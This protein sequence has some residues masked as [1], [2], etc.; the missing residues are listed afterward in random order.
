VFPCVFLLTGNSACRG[1]G[2]AGWA[3]FL[4]RSDSGAR[5]SVWDDSACGTCDARP[6]V[7]GRVEAG[8]HGWKE[9]MCAKCGSEALAAARR[10]HD[11][12]SASPAGM[13]MEDVREEEEEAGAWGPGAAGGGGSSSEPDT[14]GAVQQSVDLDAVDVRAFAAAA[15]EAAAAAAKPL[16][17]VRTDED[18]HAAG[19]RDGAREAGGGGGEGGG[20]GLDARAAG[21]RDVVS[22]AE[23]GQREGGRERE[24]GMCG[25]LAGERERERERESVLLWATLPH[26]Q[27]V[28][29]E[30]NFDVDVAAAPGAA[31]APAASADPAAHTAWA[32]SV[33]PGMYPPPHMTPYYAAIKMH[34]AAAPAARRV[35]RGTTGGAGANIGR[36]RIH[37]KGGAGAQGYMPR[38]EDT[39]QG[40]RIYAKGGAG[41]QV[42]IVALHRRCRKCPQWACFGPRQQPPQGSRT[43]ASPSHLSS[44][45]S[46]SSSISSDS[47]VEDGTVEGAGGGREGGI[48]GG[49]GREGG[50]LTKREEMGELRSEGSAA[51]W[52][53]VLG[54]EEGRVEAGGL[55]R[56][57][58]RRRRLLVRHCSLHAAIDEVFFPY[59][60]FLF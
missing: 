5:G 11:A 57:R 16:A 32:T 28:H 46:P 8:G 13:A 7:Y 58:R 35:R 14:R 43:Q 50:I 40:R 53:A 24:R 19:L 20:G 42:G 15:A 33:F 10:A 23:R 21:L 47:A 59:F 52:S 2:W 56:R 18:E 4:G 39:C 30:K 9:L 12:R 3:D 31:P 51:L 37:A 48:E 1:R 54:G 38:E 22:G 45:P 26:K 60:F 49:G 17:R 44:S 6:V 25:L 55:G 29:P 34:R 41:A 27:S 36:E